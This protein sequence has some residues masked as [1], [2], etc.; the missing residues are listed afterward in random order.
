MPQAEIDEKVRAKMAS[1]IGELRS[2]HERFTK[3]K[4]QRDG[5]PNEF[6]DDRELQRS[7]LEF[8]ESG[9]LF[10]EDMPEAKAR[11][12][13]ML[14]AK[15]GRSGS[16]TVGVSSINGWARGGPMGRDNIDAKM[17]GGEFVVNARDASHNMMALVHAN[18]GGKIK[19]Y[20]D[21]GEVG[22]YY[23][24]GGEV[25]GTTSGGIDIG[26]LNL[27]L[28]GNVEATNMLTKTITQLAANGGIIK[29]HPRGAGGMR[30]GRA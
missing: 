30:Y 11:G 17:M 21:G 25:S 13:L 3:F 14:L 16:G 1:R 22:D 10:G 6:E 2:R 7:R 28:G 12:G 5:G 26:A 24:N 29:G 19:P 15:G 23:A 27:A 4:K 9:T 18:A 8:R 20:A